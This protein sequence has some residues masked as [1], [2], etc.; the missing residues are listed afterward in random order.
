[1][2]VTL[3]GT[4][5]SVGIPV[6]GCGCEACTSPDPRDTRLRCACH[7]QVNGLSIVIDTGPDFRRQV[8]QH[9]IHRLDAVLYTH[10]HFDHIAGMDDLRPF[11]FYN[12]T[13]LPCY[14]HPQTAE[15]LRDKQAYIFG[16]DRYPSAPRLKLHGVTSPF[17]VVS[18]YGAGG[19]VEVVPIEVHHGDLPIYGY[20][21]GRF[22]YLT[23][24]NRVP[25]AS[26]EK[27]QGVSVLIIDALRHEPHPSH[28]TFDEA[29]QA[30]RRI[31]ARAAY[32]I[33]MT[34]SILHAR[35]DETLPEGIHLGYDGLTLDVCP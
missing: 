11:L 23:D 34:H 32:F 10:H 21:I 18:R 30:A 29:I 17:E 24:A 7:V 14:T 2:Q 15:I 19:S 26:Y 35:D 20:R 8:L 1:M 16:P 25:E 9:E 27:L 4:G 6:I 31:G 28:F 5:T 33:H 13:E 12:R 22:A 3:L